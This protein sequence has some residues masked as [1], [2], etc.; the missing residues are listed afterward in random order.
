MSKVEPNPPLLTV[1]R[2]AVRALGRVR[3]PD[4]LAADVASK[5]AIAIKEG[6]LRLPDAGSLAAYARTLA[7]NLHIDTLREGVRIERAERESVS[8]REKA[9]TSPQ[10]IGDEMQSALDLAVAS[11]TREQ[12]DVI[13]LRFVEDQDLDAIA[14]ALGVSVSTAHRRVRETTNALREALLK[15][16]PTNREVARLFGNRG[17]TR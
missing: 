10:G 1:A 16:A 7:R 11:L 12:R 8:L 5:L 9:L 4:G 2:D 3:D 13:R 15:Q 17:A 6:R 14:K